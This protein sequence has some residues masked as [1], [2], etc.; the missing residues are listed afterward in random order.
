VTKQPPVRS[1][2]AARFTSATLAMTILAAAANMSCSGN[3]P[4]KAQGTVASRLIFGGPPECPN[5]ITCLL[6]LQQIYHLHF[7]GFKALDEVGPLSVAALDSNSVQAVRLNSSDPSI[8]KHQFVVLQ[9]DMSFQQAGNIVPVIR[10]DKATDE[11]R[12]LLNE[13]SATMTQRD[14]FTLDSAVVGGHQD[15][16][17][18]ARR[19]V[20]QKGPETPTAPGGNISITVGSANFPENE[21]LAD[22]YIEV[23]S[24]AGYAVKAALELGSRETYEPMLEKGEVDLM[25][26]Y[27]G[28][29]LSSL[30]STINRVALSGAVSQLRESLAPKGLTVLDPSSAADSDTVVVTRATADKFHLTKISDLGRRI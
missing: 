4:P 17:A 23:L 30:S 7:R 21:M 28:N 18:V 24:R 15:P 20:Q 8:P 6:G 10:T 2:R 26:E 27:V 3:S 12:S 13:V 11:V 25:P 9:D 16:R 5:R 1:N 14:L 19:Y 29:Y 22:V